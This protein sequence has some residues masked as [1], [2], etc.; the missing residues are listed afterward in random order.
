MLSLLKYSNHLWIDKASVTAAF[1]GTPPGSKL[2]RFVAEEIAQLLSTG[3]W[4]YSDVDGTLNGTNFADDLYQV[5]ELFANVLGDERS[6]MEKRFGINSEFEDS[7]VPPTWRN[8]LVGRDLNGFSED[9]EIYMARKAAQDEEE[10]TRVMT[11]V[12]VSA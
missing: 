4:Q 3:M 10:A 1:V 6:M 9:V 2:R 7:C 12:A 8:Y 11:R 5:H